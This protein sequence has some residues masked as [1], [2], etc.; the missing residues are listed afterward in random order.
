MRM[1]ACQAGSRQAR[2]QL[3][4]LSRLAPFSL[5]GYPGLDTFA[6]RTNAIIDLL[7]LATTHSRPTSPART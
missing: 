5:I 1:L 2:R 7:A 6:Y 4:S 3:G